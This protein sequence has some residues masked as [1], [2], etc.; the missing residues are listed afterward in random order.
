MRKRPV[1][2]IEV[3]IYQSDTDLLQHMPPYGKGAWIKEILRRALQDG[4]MPKPS[5]INPEEITQQV[6]TEVTGWIRNEVMP[7]ILERLTQRTRQ[8][9][10]DKLRKMQQS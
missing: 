3:P 1:T 7:E 8:V 10:D 6:E 4:G 9:L 2:V 5:S